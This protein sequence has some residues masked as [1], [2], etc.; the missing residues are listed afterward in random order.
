MAYKLRIAVLFNSTTCT[1]Q[2]QKQ[3]WYIVTT[4]VTCRK[5]KLSLTECAD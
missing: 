5:S 1:L 3:A 4:P 2:R